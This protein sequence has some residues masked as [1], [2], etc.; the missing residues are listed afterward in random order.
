M[1]EFVVC[2]N[3]TKFIEFEV[4]VANFWLNQYCFLF[5]GKSSTGPFVILVTFITAGA[6]LPNVDLI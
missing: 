6:L 4:G 5:K 3:E 2:T 1:A